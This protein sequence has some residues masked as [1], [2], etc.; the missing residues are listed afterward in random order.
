M[1]LTHKKTPSI[2]IGQLK[3]IIYCR[4]QSSL[5]VKKDKSCAQGTY[6]LQHQLGGEGKAP[7]L[8]SQTGCLAL[9]VSGSLQETAAR[10]GCYCLPSLA[11]EGTQTAKPRKQRQRG[12]GGEG[13]LLLS[14]HRDGTGQKNPVCC[15]QKQL[16]GQVPTRT[17]FS[18]GR[19]SPS[20]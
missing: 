10:P 4:L 5:Y 8:G 2:P 18:C 13:G 20:C 17:L 9:Q 11:E 15:T 3:R 19:R 16:K 7:S 12:S 6:Q 1:N 14:G